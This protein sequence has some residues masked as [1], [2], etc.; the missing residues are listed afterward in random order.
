MNTHTDTTHRGLVPHTHTHI[1]SAHVL[2]KAGC[3]VQAQTKE[4]TVAKEPN[5][6]CMAYGGGN[7]QCA[8]VEQVLCLKE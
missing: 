5:G 4:S 7:D 2:G 3:L 1:R 6:I 8:Q